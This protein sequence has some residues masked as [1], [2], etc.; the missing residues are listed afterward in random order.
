MQ[1]KRVYHP[2]DL[3]E[4]IDANMWGSVT[5]KKKYLN[6]AIKFTGDHKR[7]GRFMM[8]VVNEWPFSCE[9]ALTDE[10]LNRRAWV[11]HAACAMALGCPEAITREAWGHLAGYQQDLANAQADNAIKVWEENYAEEKNIK[12]HKSMER[13]LL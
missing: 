1:F 9:N 12:I 5:N 7:Y 4:E 8:R 6:A 10:N 3:W 11:G 13:P 2:A